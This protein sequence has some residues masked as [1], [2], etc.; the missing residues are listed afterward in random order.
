MSGVLIYS[1]VDDH[2]YALASWAKAQK[3]ALGSVAT[4][5]LGTDAAGRA[6]AHLGYGA[7]RVYV[8]DDVA[9]KDLADEVVSSALMQIADQFKAELILLSATRRGRSLASRLAADMDA[10]CVSDAFEINV[11]DGRVVTGRYALGGNTVSREVITSAGKVVAV[12]PGTVEP[13]T[14]GDPSAEIVSAELSLSEPLTTVV[15]RKPKPA[16]TVNIAESDRLVCVGRGLAA[17]DDLKVVEELAAELTGEIACTRPLSSEYG[18]VSEER[19]IGI[20]GEK[21]SPQLML[22]LGVSGQVQHTVGIMGAK[23]IV[24]VNND[25]NAPIF[26]LADYGIVGDMYDVIPALV[27]ALK[28]RSS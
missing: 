11:E 1:E 13:G 27:K 18:W 15:E 25:A 20:S 9:L 24:A 28:E 5:V 19:M 17:K 8:C 26:K 22:S 2:A 10:G 6:E 23:V 21:C 16:S 4:A 7:E 14:A 12:T 3:D